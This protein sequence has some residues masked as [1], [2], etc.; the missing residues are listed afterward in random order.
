MIGG[1][2][3]YY[4]YLTAFTTTDENDNDYNGY[5]YDTERYLFLVSSICC[6]CIVLCW[7]AAAV[8]RLFMTQDQL[9][10]IGAY[11][12]AVKAARNRGYNSVEHTPIRNNRQTNQYEYTYTPSRYDQRTETEKHSE[13]VMRNNN[14]ISL[15]YDQ[16]M[17][18]R[19]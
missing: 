5:N 15:G 16:H 6:F 19:V 18:A 10:N 12:A 7:I 8:R 3:L 17:G 9:R 14:A 13:N 11:D 2:V 4:G 1:F